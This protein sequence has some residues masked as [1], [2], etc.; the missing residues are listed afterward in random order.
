[1]NPELQ[2]IL[3]TVQTTTNLTESE[4]ELLLR[5]VT[6][7]EKAQGMSLFKL[8]RLEKDKRTLSIM[9]EES[10]Q[11]LEHKNRDLEIESCLE[12]VRTVAMGMK[13]PGDMIEICRTISDQ[14]KLLKVENIRNVQTAIINDEKGTYLNYEY[15]TQYNTTSIS[16]V[17]PKLHP[18]VIEF[19][20]TIKK[21]AD[22][23]FTTSF[24]GK[25]LEEWRE[26][27]VTTGQTPDPML[28]TTK[29]LHY[30][31][32]SIGP[33][34]LG[35]STYSPLRE[36]EINVFKRFR[37]VF[38]L[39]YRRFIDI[40][41]AEAQAREAQIELALERVRAKAMAMQTSNDLSSAVAIIF[42]E[43]EKLS[44][45]M[46]RCG[47]AI[48]DREKRSA[49]VWTTTV[50]EHGK[51]VQVSG[52]ESMDIHP[53]LQ[54]AFDAWVRQKD[55]SYILE[56]EDLNRYYRALT[57]VNFKLPESQSF[58]AETKGLKQ[59]YYD[60]TF[61]AGG[62]F[63]FRETPFP[64]EAKIVMKR[65]ADVFTLTY[66]RFLD[67]QKAEARA[68]EAQIEAALEKVR[69]KAM[70]MHNSNDLA[71]TASAVFI[72]LRKLGINPVRAGVAMYSKNP[73]TA[74]FYGATPSSEHDSLAV[75]GSINV[76]INPCMAMQLRSWFN[77]E[78][79][80]P[81]L[82][83][84]E[85]QEYYNALSIQP[86]FDVHSD[87]AFNHK[88]Y[89]YYLH[90]SVGN[91]FTWSLKPFSEDELSILNR[92]KSI[93]DLTFRRY[94]EL[95]NAEA[96]AREAKI[97]AALERVR[98]RTM[99]MQRSDE[100]A[101]TAAI[102][103]RQLIGLG[104]APNR[105][106]IIIVK[107]DN[108]D[109][110]AWVT[111]EDGTRVSTQFTGN[112]YRNESFKKM[113][114]GWK[115][116]K[117][118][119]TIVMQGEELANYFHYL[120]DELHVPF[121]GGLSQKKRVQTVAY[122][123]KGYIG[124]ASA[125]DQPEATT[126]LLERFA[127]VF[128][129]TFTRFN[130]LKIAEAHALQAEE[131]LIK[132]QTEKKRAEDALTELKATQEQL[133]QQEKLASL[134]QLTAG[135]AHEIKNPLNFV[136]NFSQLS[137]ELVDEACDE[138][139]KINNG[140][141]SDDVYAIM[142]DIRSNLKKIHEH[143]SRADGI[144]K[145]MLHHSRGSNGKMESTDMSALIKEY[146]NLAFHGMRA[147]KNPI[148]VDIKLE[149]DESIGTVPLI[150]EDFSRVILNL[151]Q[152]AFDAMREKQGTEG[153][154]PANAKYS[155]R[156][157]VRT[158]RIDKKIQIEIEDNGPGI[159]KEI[160]DKILQPFFTTKKGTQGTGLGLSITNDIVKAHRGELKIESNGNDGAT[161]FI[162]IPA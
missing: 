50:S 118:S 141:Q 108:G 78:D 96:Q 156:L 136:N 147:G 14:L 44:L 100:L 68:K 152:N 158:K 144:V 124:L 135:I 93:I 35:V 103:F 59:Y 119:I 153:K 138:L 94:L 5:T 88:E 112:V 52:N 87:S 82:Q 128:N 62:L 63:A 32:Y 101:E 91:F 117:K 10:I 72:E 159:G 41:Q 2:K 132:L 79:Y 120:S 21:S 111:D 143:G 34:A 16:E 25:A 65:F 115:E 8:D 45:G 81:V 127:A 37:N 26:Y 9:L 104:I 95:Q 150:A 75:S 162:A 84:R 60:A 76:S 19:A 54:G 98:A 69:G 149:L 107:D 51:T 20:N 27:R 131:D 139:K 12:R 113:Y 129:L 133:I 36:E 80:F 83:G 55:F 42:E 122:F 71:E 160:K 99:A 18:T 61:Q 39:A 43:L 123:S 77:R 134:G 106:Y 7:A 64:E 15:F 90:F 92:F 130:D 29:S 3:D 22:A 40:E 28:D 109:I 125:D 102:M 73:D 33:G 11:D 48:L 66:T 151:C 53:L 114:D 97:E 4:R 137:V 86:S 105:L 57:K 30:Y 6:E 24:E 58:V 47:I 121:K 13:K 85:L 116:Q 146:V 142:D 148:N 126:Q 145:S 1:M 67:L 49:D 154:E 140:S 70:A 46:V 38:D 23:F 17:D 56:D 31:F 155:P 110:E 74:T 89:G 157:T 161:F